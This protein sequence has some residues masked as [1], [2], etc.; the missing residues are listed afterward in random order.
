MVGISDESSVV[1]ATTAEE[2]AV[3]KQCSCFNIYW[4]FLSSLNHPGANI[5]MMRWINA[6]FC[7]WLLKAWCNSFLQF[8]VLLQSLMWLLSIPLLLM[9]LGRY[10]QNTH[11]AVSMRSS[12]VT[13]SQVSLFCMLPY[14]NTVEVHNHTKKDETNNQPSWTNKLG[15]LMMALLKNTI[16]VGYT[17]E[18]GFFEPLREMK[19]GSKNQRVW[20][21][22]GKITAF[23]WGGELTFRSSYRE[24]RKGKV[25]PPKN[26]ILFLFCF[27]RDV[28][29]Q[30]HEVACKAL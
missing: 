26:S 18:S 9:S 22:R 11:I 14:W 4:T 28:S 5:L 2:G 24:V 12:K 30:W 16:T 1:N 15:Q 17:V 23:D 6:N 19:I 29:C 13:G 25:L 8:Q 27:D 3:R 10:C 7:Y 20:E 21:I